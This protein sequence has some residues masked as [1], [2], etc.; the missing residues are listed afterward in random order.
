MIEARAIRW[1]TVRQGW[2]VWLLLLAIALVQLVFTHLVRGIIDVFLL[3]PIAMASA[4]WPAAV[5]LG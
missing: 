5:S 3:M 4:W 1:E 2:K